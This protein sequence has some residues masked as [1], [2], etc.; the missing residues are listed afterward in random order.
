MGD[1]PAREGGYTDGGL[2]GDPPA[3][4]KGSIKGGLVGDPQARE[5]S[6]T[7][8]GLVKDP[9]ALDKGST[10]RDRE[11]SPPVLVGGL[12]NRG[13]H[14]RRVGAQT[15]VRHVRAFG[16]RARRLAVYERGALVREAGRRPK[17]ADC[18]A[19]PMEGGEGQGGKAGA[20]A[21][22][23]GG[24]LVGASNAFWS[25]GPTQRQDGGGI[26]GGVARTVGE[27][28]AGGDGVARRRPRGCTAPYR[29]RAGRAER[30]GPPGDRCGAVVHGAVA[31][32]RRR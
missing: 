16:R 28:V 2:V 17:A 8:G 21:R 25:Q 7:E 3:G 10:E 12:A 11:K 4:D 9:P 30:A 1:P 29:C 5:G 15:A 6:T 19:V 23:R 24:G 32:P 26:S 20:P 22:A 18:P 27:E 31:C 14:D 13:S